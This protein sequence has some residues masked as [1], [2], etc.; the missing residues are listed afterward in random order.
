M[1]DRRVLTDARDSLQ[2]RLE[3]ALRDLDQLRSGQTGG[4]LREARIRLVERHMGRL[5]RSLAKLED[6]LNEP[7]P[8]KET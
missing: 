3:R 2:A 6:V 4:R 5:V 8:R 7:Q 1:I